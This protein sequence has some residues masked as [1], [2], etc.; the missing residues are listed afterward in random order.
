MNFIGDYFALG[1]VMILGLFFFD[2]KHTLNTASKFFIGSLIFT[3][4]TSVTDIL[5]LHPN[6]VSTLPLW[7][8]IL[9][10]SLYFL[11]NILTTSCIALYLFTRILEHSHDKHCMKNAMIGLLTCLGIYSFF[12]ISN[13]WNGWM[14]YFDEYHNYCRGPLNALGYFITIAQMGLVL[15][16]YI[17]NRRNASVTMRR[18]LVET[19]PVIILCIIIQRIYPE[20]ML[21]SF[22]MSMV[23][24]ILFLTFNGQRP[25]IHSLT[26]LNDRHRFFEDLETNLKSG[27]AFQVF[28]INIK[29]FGVINQKHGHM[30]GDELLYQFAFDLEKL[31][32][33]SAAYH[34]NG[35]V[36][37]LILPCPNHQ[38]A[39]KHR[40][41]LVDF[42]ASPIK[43]INDLIMLEHVVVEYL[44]E[45]E[46]TNAAHFYELLE[47]AASK[48]YQSKSSYI[49]CTTEMGKEMRRRRYLIERMQKVDREHGF[50]VWYQP[51]RCMS[52]GKFCSMEA[53]IRMVEPDGK[54][55]SPAEFVP[56]AEQTGMIS[57]ITWF[58]LEETCRML[59]DNPELDGTTVG[60]NL[61]MAQMLESGF[62]KRVNSIVDSYGI[63]HDRIGLEFTERAIL[64]NFEQIQSVMD[65]FAKDGYRFYLDDFGAGYSNFNCLLQLPFANI[66]LDM[67]LIRMDISSN[68]VQNLGLVRTLSRFLHEM[69]LNV[70]AEGVETSEVAGVLNDIG[71]DRIQ[72]YI[73]ARPMPEDEL[74]SFYKNL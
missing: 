29:N 53:L 51:I 11:M 70:I 46:A 41:A 30:F 71:I 54:V 47:Y 28:M 31:I 35:T 74:M 52:S 38:T 63:S 42:M 36:F 21:N 19:F 37:A 14:F 40:T 73:Y 62:I 10:N 56:L 22:I 5:T 24:A 33:G 59:R 45:N 9:I 60:V 27:D 32:K 55:I 49:R 23:A 8:N 12:V 72:G 66:K 6:V 13:I 18:V 48:A 50:R 65:R 68:G 2:R 61:P 25:G 67:D 39:E 20:I 34:M 3:A 26:K 44:A 15:I 69:N 17:R 64:E 58:V 16:C 7:A 57:S 4:A 1:L 43:C